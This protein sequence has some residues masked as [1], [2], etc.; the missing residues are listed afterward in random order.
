V[1]VK[2][3]L[4]VVSGRLSICPMVTAPLW[5]KGRRGLSAAE[6]G[7]AP[8]PPFSASL[9]GHG[10]CRPASELLTVE[11]TLLYLEL[12]PLAMA[13]VPSVL[14]EGRETGL[15]LLAC[16][17]GSVTAT[18]VVVQVVSCRLHIAATSL[19]LGHCSCISV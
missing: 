4:V 17:K 3:L 18:E 7:D 14:G 11:A 6:G 5:E 2:L 1:G 19:M 8:A 15:D 9:S 13:V 12:L 16:N 10:D